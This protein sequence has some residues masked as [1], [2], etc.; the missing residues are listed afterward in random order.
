MRV[1]PDTILDLFETARTGENVDHI[2]LQVEDADLA[3]V[4][5]SGRFDVVR[6]PV[7]VFGARGTGHGLYIRDP[8]GNTIEL[9][10]YP[11]PAAP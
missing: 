9:R 10:T 7:E 2:A 5:A 11:R 4:A 3:E 6:G 8:D 1:S